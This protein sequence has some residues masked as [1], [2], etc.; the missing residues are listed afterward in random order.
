ME[1]KTTFLHSTKKPKNESKIQ[2]SEKET[3][4]ENKNQKLRQGSC[5]N[6]LRFVVV[7]VY[8]AFFSVGECFSQ[9]F[10]TETNLFINQKYL[11]EL[12]FI[13]I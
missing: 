6:S 7:V 3:A 10:L 8:F 11:N 12:Q 1:E 13:H 5:R 2:K 9:K 4:T